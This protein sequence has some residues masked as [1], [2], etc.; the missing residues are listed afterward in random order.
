LISLILLSETTTNKTP[1]FV[2]ISSFSHF[3]ILVKF[4]NSHI[5]PKKL[6]KTF[7]EKNQ[8][9]LDIVQRLL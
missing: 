1:A 8:I 5:D 6:S 4:D 3:L 2:I 9:F 7:S